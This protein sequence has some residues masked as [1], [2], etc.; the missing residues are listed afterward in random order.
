GATVAS[1]REQIGEVLSP[2]LRPADLRRPDP[3]VGA[4]RSVLCKPGDV[5]EF[6]EAVIG[7]VTQP[8]V[9]HAPGRNARPAAV[10]QYSWERHVERLWTRAAEQERE[11]R[12]SLLKLEA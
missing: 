8:A 11:R 5:D 4:E 12:A 7:L 10:G 3:V 6:V 9:A 2:A 1:D